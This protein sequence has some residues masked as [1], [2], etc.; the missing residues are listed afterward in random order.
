MITAQAI[1]DS[2]TRSEM[3][4]GATATHLAADGVGAREIMQA[5]VDHRCALR[6]V[7]MSYTGNVADADDLIQDTAIRALARAH[8]YDAGTDPA[9]WLRK[10]MFRLFLDGHRRQQTR[11]IHRSLEDADALAPELDLEE[12]APHWGDFTMDDVAEVLPRLSARLRQ[13]YEMHVGQRLSYEEIAARLGIPVATVGTRLLR[14]RSKLRSLLVERGPGAPVTAI[15]QWRQ[16]AAPRRPRG[17]TA[18]AMVA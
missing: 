16:P 17:A 9:A 8:R 6:R 14:A 1:S 12:P 15:E 7:A 4:G 3:L 13:V 2:R 5:L 18:L 10:V 11:G